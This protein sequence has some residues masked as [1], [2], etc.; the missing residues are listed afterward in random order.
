MKE[1]RGP[2]G[3]PWRAEV[4]APSFSNVM[5]VFRHPDASSSSR[6]RYA[7]YIWHGAEARNVTARLTAKQVLESLTDAELARLFRRSMPISTVRPVAAPG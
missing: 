6:N 7:W 4:R 5:I 2:D 1:F 3:T